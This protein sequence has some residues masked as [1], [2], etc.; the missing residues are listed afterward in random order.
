M[1]I[2]DSSKV[3]LLYKKLFGVAKTDTSTNKGASNESIASP[4]LNRGDKIWVSAGD[5]P[6][7]P[8]ESDTSIVQVYQNGTV[9]QCVADTTTVSISSVYPTWKTNL[10]DWIPSEFGSNYFIKVYADNAGAPNAP[11]SGTQIFDS[12]IAGVGEW[13][14]DYQS[15]VLNFIGGT[16]PAALTSS[17][18]I[19]IAGYRYVG[20]IGVSNINPTT[21]YTTANTNQV[22]FDTL[23]TTTYR[24][25][26]YE[27]QITSGSAYE[28]TELRLLFD[29]PNAYLTEYGG[30]GDV[31]GTFASYYNPATNNY[32]S[33]NINIGGI[34]V[35][36]GT[37]FRVY[38]TVDAVGLGLLS[39][40]V[41]TVV[42]V[43]DSL[44]NSYTITLATAF[45]NTSEG[46][47]DATSTVSR[48]PTLLI[49]NVAW[50]GSG[51]VEL[52][53]TPINS[54]TTLKYVKTIIE[55]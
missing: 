43:K 1:A 21:T 19:Y 45:V 55:V 47:Y 5:I 6:G 52:R 13:F 30:I 48:S 16:I 3:D 27:M 31:L 41:G 33:P 22:T 8:P 40:P 39:I 54:S 10:T 24:S 14:F 28:A 18:V 25:A 15:G 36:N 17:K 53:F 46:I 51:L 49:S 50:T 37:S 7:T 32:S 38:T 42:T 4:A 9:V 11:N 2:T 29:S 35:W 34:S 23:D 20:T 44:N 12:G 26:K